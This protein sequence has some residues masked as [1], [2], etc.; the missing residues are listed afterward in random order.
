MFY[1][2]FS[3]L[4]ISNYQSFNKNRNKNTKDKQSSTFIDNNVLNAHTI[5]YKHAVH[6][7]K[8]INLYLRKYIRARG[9]HLRI[10]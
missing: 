2:S 4:V 7:C 10:I 1:V 9:A 6:D 5:I 8:Y 3:R